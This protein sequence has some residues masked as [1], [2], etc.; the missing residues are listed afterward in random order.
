M[1]QDPPGVLQGARSSRMPGMAQGP[2][3]TSL[4]H[5]T[6]ALQLS[7]ALTPSRLEAHMELR[8]GEPQGRDQLHSVILQEYLQ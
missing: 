2:S 1:G 5:L 8:Q 6:R 3:G 7:P 4:Q